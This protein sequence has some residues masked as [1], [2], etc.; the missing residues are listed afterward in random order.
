MNLNLTTGSPIILRILKNSIPV[1]GKDA[2]RP[3]KRTPARI[4]KLL[5]LSFLISKSVP[6]SVLSV[7]VTWW[8][9]T[10]SELSDF[11]VTVLDLLRD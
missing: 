2:G 11:Q 4:G 5:T 8:N 9:V 3:H 6:H 1:K 7:S 10:V